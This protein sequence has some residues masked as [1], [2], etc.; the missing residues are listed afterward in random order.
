MILFAIL[1]YI[2]I[3]LTVADALA[4]LGVEL[5][6]SQTNELFD[7]YD[8]DKGGSI[9]LAEFKCLMSDTQLSGLKPNRDVKY[10]MNMFKKYDADG[11]G[12]IDKTEFR[13]IAKVR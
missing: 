2:A 11:S 1:L 5:S 12:E 6:E 3:I 13:A 9:D 4:D 8:A 10:A 7:K